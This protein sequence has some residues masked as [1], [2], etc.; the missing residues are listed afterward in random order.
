MLSI[1]ISQEEKR[2]KQEI[3]R[4][5]SKHQQLEPRLQ[6]AD[7]L[8]SEISSLSREFQHLG[9]LYRQQQEET[10]S[11]RS[12]HRQWWEWKVKCGVLQRERDD[13]LRKVQGLVQTME[14]CQGQLKELEEDKS[15]KEAELEKLQIQLKEERGHA[16]NKIQ[17]NR[18]YR[19][20]I[21]DY[22]TNST[23]PL[24]Y[25]NSDSTSPFITVIIHTL[26]AQEDKYRSMKVIGQQLESY[27]M[28]LKGRPVLQHKRTQCNKH[29]NTSS[30]N[31]SPPSPPRDLEHNL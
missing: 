15:R 5:T 17:V 31:S 12:Q 19:G 24:L 6:Q 8:Q 23:L 26:Q 2:S 14:A 16:W 27:I 30:I 28:E 20:F 3:F 1:S 13:A 10:L 9:E 11:L 25:I 18:Q 29:H 7:Q 21:T 22:S 4:L